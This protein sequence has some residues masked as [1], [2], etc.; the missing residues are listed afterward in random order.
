[1]QTLERLEIKKPEK[2]ESEDAQ[3]TSSAR[4]TGSQHRSVYC[5]PA[6]DKSMRA[7]QVC[8]RYHYRMV[9]EEVGTP[10]CRIDDLE[11]ALTA[12]CGAFFGESLFSRYGAVD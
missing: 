10:V 3:S 8:H 4:P 11:H 5:T 2:K 6:L 12:Y 9:M 1:V 7:S